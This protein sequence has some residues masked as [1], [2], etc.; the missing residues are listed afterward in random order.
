MLSTVAEIRL[1]VVVVVVVVI[2]IDAVRSAASKIKKSQRPQIMIVKMNQT[3][4]LFF[5]SFVTVIQS[6]S[7][8]Y[9]L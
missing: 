9:S 7:T 6:N 8:G 3:K 1:R 2:T 4:S 5:L